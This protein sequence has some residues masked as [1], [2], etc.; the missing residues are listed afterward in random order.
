MN[1][2]VNT[3][4]EAEPTVLSSAVPPQQP[5]QSRRKLLPLIAVL[6]IVL[7]VGGF[8]LLHK[9]PTAKKDAGSHNASSK[10]VYADVN[11][12]DT[13]HLPDGKTIFFQ[14]MKHAN[15]QPVIAATHSD[16]FVN[17]DG[18]R[19][20]R[21]INFM[22]NSYTWKDDK[23][24]DY[25]YQKLPSEPNVQLSRCIHNKAAIKDAILVQGIGNDEWHDDQGVSGFGNSCSDP[26]TS[27]IDGVFLVGGMTA[28]NV[29]KWITA[30]NALK[31]TSGSTPKLVFETPTVIDYNGKKV[32][33]VVV[34]VNSIHDGYCADG[35]ASAPDYC[36]SAS[37]S[38]AFET[39][40]KI[41][42]SKDGY[43]ALLHVHDAAATYKARY[44]IDP[45]TNLPIYMRNQ[46]ITNPKASYK[47]PETQELG[48]RIEAAEIQYTEPNWSLI[49]KDTLSPAAQQLKDLYD[50]ATIQ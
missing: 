6:V 14:M 41:D 23:L 20:M 3:P 16:G 47:D 34:T 10:A 24:A 4:S 11:H 49:S 21:E 13:Q 37:I 29:D 50:S 7:I 1:E 30:I 27:D 8:L 42:A 43:L 46:D 35:G 44:Y 25:S 9:K 15:L 48:P 36:G 12:L 2:D 26:A 18:K 19:V 22:Q 5:F 28:T 45:A 38:G 32:V 31:D 17:K 33:Q 40:T 39:S